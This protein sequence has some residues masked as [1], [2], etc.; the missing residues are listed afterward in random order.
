MLLLEFG[1]ELECRYP[2]EFHEKSDGFQLE[3]D[4]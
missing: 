2:D 3:G 1:L 4:T